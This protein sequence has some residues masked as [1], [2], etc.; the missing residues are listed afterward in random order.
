L[1][2][3]L[4]EKGVSLTTEQIEKMIGASGTTGTT[5]TGTGT[6]GKVG[7]TESYQNFQSHLDAV[8]TAFPNNIN[9]ENLDSIG[10]QMATSAPGSW[11]YKT[12]NAGDLYKDKTNFTT[13]PN[14]FGGVYSIS[15]KT[16][17]GNDYLWF[18]KFMDEGLTEAQAMDLAIPAIGKE[19]MEKAYK[20]VTGSDFGKT[21]FNVTGGA[22]AGVKTGTV[23]A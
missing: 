20:A 7:T 17:E 9:I 4:K 13:D 21:G 2:T 3:A 12:R 1:S 23:I 16:Q 10:K 18:K 8:S 14:A 6:S 15:A 22:N 5:G 19:R 11:V